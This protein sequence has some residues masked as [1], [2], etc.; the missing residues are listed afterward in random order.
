MKL[1]TTGVYGLV[2]NPIYLADV[3]WPLGLAIIMRSTYG[4]AL[5]PVWWAI[6]LIHTLAEEGALERA[7]GAEYRNYVRKVP[8]RI[9]P[10]LP[11]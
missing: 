1:I 4:V 6:F 11:I 2:R 3:L 9:F 8:G 5:T 10:W 7:L